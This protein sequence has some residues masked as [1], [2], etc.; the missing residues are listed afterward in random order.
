MSDTSPTTVGSIVG[1]LHMDRAEWKANVAQ[2]KEDA[3]ELGNL[4]PDIHIDDN[5]ATVIARMN[6]ARAAADALAAKSEGIGKRE[7][8]TKQAIIAAE[9]RVQAGV[10]ASEVATDALTA[11]QVR[12]AAAREAGNAD[13]V[14]REEAK[15]AAWTEKLERANDATARSHLELAAAQR[16]QAAAAVQ[17][18]E[19]NKTSVTRVGAIVTA[20]AL[21]VP[22][23]AP[24]GAAAVGLG[25]AF[26][27]MGAAG[28][29]ALFGIHQEMKKGTDTGKAYQAGLDAL[30]AA[31]STLAQTAAVNMLASFRRAVADTNA[32]MPMLNKQVGQFSSLL[33]QA[34]AAGLSGTI[35][36]LRVLNPL[37]LTAGIYI[38]S[39]AEG[40]E[41]WAN[42][43]GIESFNAYAL[44]TFP[45]VV[46]VL[47]KLASMVM[48][49][50][51]ALAPLGT[52]GLAVLTGVADM[53]NA[54]PV[55]VLSQLIVS[56]TW[57]AV[58]FKSW[59][60]VAPL[61]K[62]IAVDMG[63]VGIAT[64]L[65][66]GPIGWVV[67]GLA[68]L[69]G[70]FAVVIANNTG[71]TQAIQDYTYAVQ[72]D[73]GAIG[74]NVRAKAAQ[75]L[76]DAGA[77]DA[78]KKLGVAYSTVTDAA[79]GNKAAQDELNKATAEYGW[80]QVPQAKKA[81]EQLGITTG[82]LVG[83]QRSLKDAVNSTSADISGA[84][85]RYNTLQGA[86]AETT[87]ATKE[88]Q[89][90]DEAAAAALGVSVGAVQAARD[91]QGK[92]EDA[93]AKATAEMYLQGDAAGLLKQALDNLNGKALS[94]AEAQNQFESQLV[95]LPDYINEV[96]GEYDANG[97]ALDGM[98]ESAINNRG[99]L[100]DLIQSSEAAVTA[101]RDQGA[102]Q[103][104]V[105]AKFEQQKQAIEDQAV[106]NGM[107]RD[108]VHAYLEQLY[109]IPA[110]IPKTKIEVDTATANA[111]LE[112]FL[113]RVSSQV[114]WINVKATMPD[115][116]GA[117][118]GSGRPGVALGGTIRGLAG[119]GSGGTVT[120][121]GTAGSDTAGLFRLARGEEVV[122]NVF[123]QA[124]RNR[125]LLKQINAGYTPSSAASPAPASTAPAATIGKE[126]PVI[127]INVTGVNQEDPRVLGM[128]IGGEVRR[129]LTGRAR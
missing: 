125:A 19:A 11:A 107:N 94:A 69:A 1:K 77:Y 73:T 21:L 15:L 74:E 100:L 12:L 91:G 71:A 20:I 13:K 109:K 27:G 53:I 16:A 101:F 4:R 5:A 51:E 50:L 75:K 65:A 124:D 97:A 48:H 116:N 128:I 45:M 79:L 121:P 127:N 98:S 7:L 117:V 29:A 58:A 28:V 55:D 81:A 39:L 25:G 14:A 104:D 42:G 64:K 105:K 67:A 72:E 38:R 33:G 44:A 84:V 59:G 126:A 36:S 93:T 83:A 66:V 35:S 62:T 129:A 49:L 85:A 95:R 78:A 32:A 114:A 111:Q 3:R 24:V 102:S 56:V 122:S 89:W 22:L 61:L 30:G 68:A 26:L 90:A 70:M 41:R 80:G 106:A 17:A 54:I 110:E 18:N 40:F 8:T 10:R 47:G 43:T 103:E 23:L 112:A 119:G 115:L 82:D 52:I 86:L 99:A 37:F 108:S 6:A 31:M 57:G 120:G 60:F 46:D 88:Q 123:G 87:S 118:S 9:R 96:T 92:L 2:T 76:Q 34:G 113:A 63:A